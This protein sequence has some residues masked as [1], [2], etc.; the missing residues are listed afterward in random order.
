MAKATAKAVK[1]F[2]MATKALITALISLG[3]IAVLILIIVILFADKTAFYLLHTTINRIFR[4]SNS[5]W[6][7]RILYVEIPLQQTAKA[8]KQTARKAAQGAKQSAKAA[9]KMD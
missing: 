3:W 5:I 8:A 2:I 6:L 9:K 1:A 4:I 7:F